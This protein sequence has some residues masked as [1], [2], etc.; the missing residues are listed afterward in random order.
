MKATDN[1][2]KYQTYSMYKIRDIPREPLC[3]IINVVLIEASRNMGNEFNDKML[4]AIISTIE[5]N[6]YQLPLSYIVSAIYKGSMGLLGPG[7]LIPRT[8]LTWIREV[9]AEYFKEIEHKE[10]QERL[11][12]TGTPVDLKR[13]PMGTALNLKIDWLSSGAIISEEWDKIPLKELA[14]I[15]GQKKIPQLSDFGIYK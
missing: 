10:V 2:A 1:N 3:E 7:R 13:Y 12:I 6:N 5:E 14:D 15:I 8:I 9:S 4:D 11:K